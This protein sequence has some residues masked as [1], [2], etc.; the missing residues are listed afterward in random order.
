M[1]ASNEVI[2]KAK[3]KKKHYFLHLICY[4]TQNKQ[5]HTFAYQILF[6]NQAH[7]NK[8]MFSIKERPKNET[9][10]FL[11]CYSEK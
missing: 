7:M 8:F 4:L 6:Q 3:K 2:I 9:I 5:K 1:L 11:S 10:D